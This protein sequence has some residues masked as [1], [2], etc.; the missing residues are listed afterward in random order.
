M[1]K[2]HYLYKIENKL[3]GKIYIGVHSTENINDGYMGSSALLSKSIK[4]YGKYNFI[5]TILEY[6][7]SRELLMKLEKK[8]V[9]EEFV[10]R[11]NTYNL[12]VGGAGETSTW[13][14]SN[15][16]ISHKLKNDPAWTEKRNHNISL[17]IHKAISDGK[18]STATREFQ[19]LRN[20]KSLT[21]ESIK[22]R[23]ETYAK[24]KHQQ[25]ENNFRYGK[26]AINNDIT[27]KWVQKEEVDEYL[28]SGWKLGIL[29]TTKEI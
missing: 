18:C 27:W 19:L 17:G 23:K 12:S 7:D 3:N 22:K 20:K 21:E 25:G 14:K 9:N 5:K 15:K 16:T 24:N 4:K 8:V 2:I 1:A 26:K 11:R 10:N 28:S 6:C 29:K 13:E